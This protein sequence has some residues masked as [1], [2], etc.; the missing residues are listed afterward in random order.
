MGHAWSR[1][2]TCSKPQR[3]QS[4]NHWEFQLM[5]FTKS[6]DMEQLL[7]GVCKL[8]FLRKDQMSYS[9]QEILKAKLNQSKCTTNKFN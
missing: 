7:S 9:L 2:L 5:M 8:E 6:R 1:L 4:R 3:D